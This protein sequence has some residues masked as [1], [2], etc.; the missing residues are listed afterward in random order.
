MASAKEESG[1]SMEKEIELEELKE[2]MERENSKSRNQS[3]SGRSE[4]KSKERSGSVRQRSLSREKTGEVGESVKGAVK[5]AVKGVGRRSRSPLR[6]GVESIGKGMAGLTISTSDD[7]EKPRKNIFD[8][9]TE[10]AR[11]QAEK[12]AES[13]LKRQREMHDDGDDVRVEMENEGF[14][15]FRMA[16]A[17]DEEWLDGQEEYESDPTKIDNGRGFI[18]VRE[19]EADEGRKKG[20]CR[21]KEGMGGECR[22]G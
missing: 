2:R 19:K 12:M 20:G 21:M 13:T 17:N 5:E 15:R 8:A 22:V 6:K 18:D 11:M 16:T 9:M 7:H 10:V 14:G 1:M 4:R 3:R